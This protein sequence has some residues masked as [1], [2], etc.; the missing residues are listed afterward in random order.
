METTIEIISKREDVNPD[1]IQTTL[2]Y[3]KLSD[4]IE[5][6]YNNISAQGSSRSGKTV[7]IILWLILYALQHDNTRISVV[8]RSLPALRATVFID[9]MDL[10]QKM[11]IYDPP[12]HNKTEMLYRFENGS[13][14]E[15]FSLD[16][17]QK[18]RGRKRNVLF[19]NEA[20]ELDFVE[21]QQ[22]RMRTSAFAI[23]DYNPSFSEDHWICKLSN[24]PKTFH[25]ITTFKDNPFLEQGIIDELL[26]L[27]TKNKSLWQIYGLGQRA[28]IE[29]AIF[30]IFE[31]VERFPEHLVEKASLSLDWGFSNDPTAIILCAI[32]G[33][34]L[35]LDEV[36]YRTHMLASDIINE[37]KR[38][39]KLKVICDSAD[40]RMVA[41]V[42]NAGINIVPVQ[43]YPGSI[44]SGISKMQEYKICISARSTNA[45]K[46]FRN[47]V[48]RQDKDGV[49]LN[50]P[51]PGADHLIDSA[52]YYIMTEV[53]GKSRR[54]QNLT[55]IFY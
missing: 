40:P 38:A 23:V 14:F 21:W 30:P 52:R 6:G 24:D 18:I 13:W 9:F 8:R 36:C 3:T 2:V 27:E 5:Q 31:V 55:G 12:M 45:I 39:P 29:G 37:L 19:I 44:L 35:Y 54:R 42:R 32:E 51:A 47:Y 1:I 43:K 17:E 49:W 11:D 10:L 26:S 33:D 41:E 53:L 28:I 22:L 48:Y 20:N 34:N 50:E 25:F 4:A 15:F 16:D 46:E 7:N